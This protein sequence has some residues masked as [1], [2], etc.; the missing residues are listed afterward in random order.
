MI[1]VNPIT[2]SEVIGLY[3]K[4]CKPKE[5][6]EKCG[7]GNTTLYRILEKYNIKVRIGALKEVTPKYKICK[8]CGEKYT[9]QKDNSFKQFIVRKYCSQKC[10]ADSQKGAHHGRIPKT[11]FK[12]GNTPWNK[13]KTW[14][15][16][17]GENH[18]NFKPKVSVNCGNCGKLIKLHPYRVKKVKANYCSQRCTVLSQDHPQFNTLPE[19]ILILKKELLK[20]GFKEN[21]DFI[22]QYKFFNKYKCDFAFP[23]EKLIVEVQGDFWHANPQK[24]E[25][26][27]N[28]PE[29][30]LYPVQVKGINRDEKKFAYIRKC[31]WRILPLWEADI[32]DEHNR[33]ILVGAIKYNLKT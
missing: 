5:I 30:N 23:K 24:N 26:N 25:V 4:G 27:P 8:K 29:E 33:K 16:M 11:A 12:K 6:I 10:F 15:E 1:K 31:G 14:N 9:R 3:E 18:P 13:G 21:I 22:H 28:N 17:K 19:R 32:L 20:E 2:E 7:I